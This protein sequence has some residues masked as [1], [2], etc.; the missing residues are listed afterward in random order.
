MASREWIES[1]A[2]KPSPPAAAVGFGGRGHQLVMLE[3]TDDALHQGALTFTDRAAQGHDCGASKEREIVVC[4]AKGHLRDVQIA[5]EWLEA[6]GLVQGPPPRLK[7]AKTT[8]VS[9][10]AQGVCPGCRKTKDV[11]VNGT[12]TAH[13]I[14]GERCDGTGQRPVVEGS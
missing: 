11:R 6:V 3:L 12:M 10:K 13:N 4:L 1:A 7:V 2:R 14:R 9:H 5:R 8:S